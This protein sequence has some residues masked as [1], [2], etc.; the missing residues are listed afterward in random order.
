MAEVIPASLSVA[1]DFRAATS[2]AERRDVALP[3]IP[4]FVRTTHVAWASSS[5]IKSEV[6]RLFL[7]SV[8]ASPSLY[9]ILCDHW[10]TRTRISLSRSRGRFFEQRGKPVTIEIDASTS[11]SG[12]IN[13]SARMPIS[14]RHEE[15]RHRASRIRSRLCV[16]TVLSARHQVRTP[17]GFFAQCRA[18]AGAELL[19]NA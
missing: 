12:T 4:D 7:L 6:R 15:R 5:L 10:R 19:N 2:S 13:G 14:T 8:I 17:I 18:V 16:S 9:E 3:I 1:R 11:A